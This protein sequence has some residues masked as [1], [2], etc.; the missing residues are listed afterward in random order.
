MA[1]VLGSTTMAQTKISCGKTV[2]AS[3]NLQ[4]ASNAVDCNTGT[5]WE[6]NHG[7]ANQWIYV[8]LGT[9]TPISRVVL[10]WEAANAR[11]YTIEGSNDPYF[12]TKVTLATRTNMPSS[13]RIDD[14]TSLSGTFR[15]VRMYGTLRNLTYGYSLWEF[16]VYDAPATQ[17][18]FTSNALPAG[19]G[20]VAPANRSY[21]A[22]T[23]V[24]LTATATTG[25]HFVNWSGDASG[26]AAST[27][28]TMNSS[29]NVTANFVPNLTTYI[30]STNALPAGFGSV[31]LLPAGNIYNAGTTVTVTA[32]PSSGYTFVSWSGAATSTNPS[33]QVAMNSDLSLTA[34]FQLAPG[35]QWLAN[36]TNLYY[37]N[38]NVGIGGLSPCKLT[39]AGSA[40]IDTFLAF[41]GNFIGGNTASS[42]YIDG[43]GLQTRSNDGNFTLSLGTITTSLYNN[44]TTMSGSGIVST[45]NIQADT[46]ICNGIKVNG[47]RSDVMYDVD[48]NEYHTVKIGTQTWTVENLATT[49]FNDWASIRNVTDNSAWASLTTPAY[50]WY[51]NDKATNGATFGAL[52][53]GYAIT[54]GKLAPHG[55]HI[56]TDAE[57][58]VLENYLVAHGYNWDKS[59][60]GIKLAQSMGA[61]TEWLTSTVSGAPGNNLGRNN[62][63][64]FSALPGGYRYSDGF[65]SL[66]DFGEWW[67]TSE[68][69]STNML[70]RTIGSSYDASYSAEDPK[71]CGF[72]VRLIRDN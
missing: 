57:W 12:T 49:S 71:N 28:I 60:T 62:R 43:T 34:A 9:S 72:S 52:Y 30:L 3:T 59:L 41:N 67:S 27:S 32:L 23:A 36:G 25:Y 58:T 4:S 33:I 6:S 56:P 13:P 7:T 63:T 14:I 68:S 54:S 53:N 31:T 11:D 50:C 64:G 45:K 10:N 1:G 24:S 39:V 19:S 47:N 29:K 55:W 61:K 37:N 18:S 22:G 51:N 35:N 38:G 69:G 40:Q 8:D 42:L 48:G 17:Y 16:E 20:S 44:Q 15:Y 65:A 26:T 5:R 46:L 21:N 66:G 70:N 2:Q